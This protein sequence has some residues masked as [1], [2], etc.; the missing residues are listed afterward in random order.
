MVLFLA[1]VFVVGAT[2]AIGRTTVRALVGRGHEVVCMVRPRAEDTG[3]LFAG[4]EARFGS[5]TDSASLTRDGFRGE[6][7]DAMVSC[8][9][10]RTGAPRERLTLPGCA[11]SLEVEVRAI[12]GEDAHVK[13]AE[14]SMTDEWRAFVNLSAAPPQPASLRLA[15]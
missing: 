4:A 15:A 3:P 2:G 12:D 13:L 7:F 8:L 9:A 10:S 6:R 5:V 1:R 11:R 14:A